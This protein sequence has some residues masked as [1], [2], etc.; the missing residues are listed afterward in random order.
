MCPAGKGSSTLEWQLTPACTGGGVGVGV[1]GREPGFV[2]APAEWLEFGLCAGALEEK[3]QTLKEKLITSR[4]SLPNSEAL[5]SSSLHTT[6]LT[7]QG[8]ALAPA[9]PLPP[10]PQVSH[11]ASGQLEKLTF[12]ELQL[13]SPPQRGPPTAG[14]PSQQRLR[15]CHWR[16]GQGAAC[17]PRSLR[18]RHVCQGGRGGASTTPGTGGC[19][20]LENWNRPIRLNQAGPWGH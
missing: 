17:S 4:R 13:L 14:R 5:P 6:P 20:G 3:Q 1:G 2:T 16:D 7:G 19:W 12:L 8:S 15:G 11:S 10:L 18:E 9:P